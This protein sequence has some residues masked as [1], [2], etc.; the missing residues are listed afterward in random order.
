MTSR[1]P[2]VSPASIM[3]VVRSSNTAGYRRM[4]LASVEPPSTVVRTPVSVFWNVT[5]S[6]LAA[7]ISRHCTSGNPAS[8][9]TENWRK[10]TAT[11]FTLTLLVPNVG[12]TN[13]LPFSRIA[14]GVIRSRRNCWPSACLLGATRSPETFC[15][16]ASLPENVKTGMVLISPQFV[17]NSSFR[18][19][20]YW[21][22]TSL[23]ALTMS[24]DALALGC[25]SSGRGRILGQARATINHFLQFIRMTR[26][27]QRHFQRNLLLEIRRSQRLVKGLHTELV[28]PGLHR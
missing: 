13:S 25:H 15:P 2:P 19:R 22:S 16:E 20:N 5:F 28:L 6:W 4:A 21:S 23:L 10:K 1:I 18:R 11:S 26:A 14:P 27:L 3:F 9:I 12:I 8:I 24:P 7:R 17:G